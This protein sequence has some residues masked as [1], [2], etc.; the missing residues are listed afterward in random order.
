M[1]STAHLRPGPHGEEGQGRHGLRFQ[2]QD[3]SGSRHCCICDKTISKAEKRQHDLRVGSKK[4]VARIQA[5]E[6]KADINLDTPHAHFN[7][8]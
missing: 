7:S 4:S 5:I 2:L 1:K 6:S 8:P 3:A